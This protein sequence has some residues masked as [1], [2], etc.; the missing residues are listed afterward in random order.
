MTY[1]G[2]TT[3]ML[4]P[5][6]AARHSLLMKSPRGC[7][8]ERALGAVSVVN[9]E[10]AMFVFCTKVKGYCEMVGGKECSY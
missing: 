6:F 10:E 1:I 4:S 9:K 3:V 8:N 5:D 7:S 2:L